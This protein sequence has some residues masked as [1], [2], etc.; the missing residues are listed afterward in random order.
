M[1]VFSL[2]VFVNKGIGHD[3]HAI[4]VLFAN[5][6][7]KLKHHLDH[8]DSNTFT[9][10][11]FASTVLNSLLIIIEEI[12]DDFV[13]LFDAYVDAYPNVVVYTRYVSDY[14]NFDNVKNLDCKPNWSNVN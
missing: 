2:N 9:Y 14:D 11:A 10:V 6:N 7:L 13:H 8:H 4:K 5:P 1:E 12:Y 3:A